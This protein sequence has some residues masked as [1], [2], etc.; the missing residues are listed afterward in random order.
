MKREIGRGLVPGSPMEGHRDRIARIDLPGEVAGHHCQAR[1]TVG[2]AK[3]SRSGFGESAFELCCGFLCRGFL[4]P[5]RKEGDFWPFRGFQYFSR[6]FLR[7]A[8]VHRVLSRRRTR[9]NP[10]PFPVQNGLPGLPLGG[11]KGPCVGNFVGLIPGVALAIAQDQTLSDIA[12]QMPEGSPLQ[13]E[14]KGLASG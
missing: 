9:G 13:R 10:Q 11:R 1:E 2:R 4:H 14:P 8:Q 12:G 5:Q 6:L 7:N 3:E